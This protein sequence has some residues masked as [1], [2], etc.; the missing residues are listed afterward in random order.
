[1]LR[2]KGYN[3][4]GFVFCDKGG[5][6]FHPKTVYIHFKALLERNGPRDCRF[7]DMRGMMISTAG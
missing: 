2:Y 4:Q 6:P 7:H 3:N 5:K 1:M